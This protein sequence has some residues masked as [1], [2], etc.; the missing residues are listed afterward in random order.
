MPML[1]PASPLTSTPFRR[2]T[3]AGRC[4]LLFLISSAIASAAC[5]KRTALP[6][7]P[8]DAASSAPAPIAVVPPPVEGSGEARSLTAAEIR[9]GKGIAL[10][11]TRK[12]D[13]KA[14]LVEEFGQPAPGAPALVQVKGAVLG[15]AALARV[16]RRP[17]GTLPPSPPGDKNAPGW[18]W[19]VRQP[20]VYGGAYATAD[21]EHVIFC[22]LAVGKALAQAPDGSSEKVAFKGATVFFV[23]RGA[24]GWSV[25]APL[26][27]ASFGAGV[28]AP[29]SFRDAAVW[30]LAL[31]VAPDRIRVEFLLD[32]LVEPLYFGADRDA[33]DGRYEATFR[34]PSLAAEGP[35]VRKGP[36]E[37]FGPTEP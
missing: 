33:R 23:S 36:W 11:R 3:G 18:E 16:A 2:G 1:P 25:P 15:T 19:I 34:R 37:L 24:N 32:S 6:P 31:R 20:F 14:P 30:P 28:K 7:P 29:V 35:P 21:G 12:R 22:S 26:V 13:P 9:T 17:D 5:R 10:F 4:A 8:V 27:A